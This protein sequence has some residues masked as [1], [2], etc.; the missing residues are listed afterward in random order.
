ALAAIKRPD[1]FSALVM[2]GPSPSYLDRPPYRG[3]FSE[4]DIK[5]LLQTL[6]ENY[7]GWAGHLASMVA[8]QQESDDVEQ[9]LNNR[10]CRNDPEISRHFARV[11]FLADNRADLP[12]VRTP[13]L[14]IQSARDA[15]ADPEVGEYVHAHIPDSRLVHIDST[16]HAPHMTHPDQVAAAIRRFLAETA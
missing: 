1:L 10:F 15:I 14:V 3:G 4:T 2:V 12:K 9:Q 5:G 7:V 6:D 11:T 16:G 8:G 13:T